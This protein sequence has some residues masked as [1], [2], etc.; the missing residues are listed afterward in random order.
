[1]SLDHS[2]CLARLAAVLYH[3]WQADWYSSFSSLLYATAQG[4]CVV[5]ILVSFKTDSDPVFLHLLS[6]LGGR[7]TLIL[8]TSLQLDRAAGKCYWSNSELST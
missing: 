4:V 2:F 1:M 7:L 6:W 3:S 5:V 8:H